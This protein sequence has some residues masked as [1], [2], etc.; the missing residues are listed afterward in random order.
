MLRQQGGKLEFIF[1]FIQ[2]SFQGPTVKSK[3]NFFQVVKQSW[4]PLI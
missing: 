2:K 1:Y 4:I 3:I